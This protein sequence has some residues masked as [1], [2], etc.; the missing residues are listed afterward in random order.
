MRVVVVF[1]STTT[2]DLRM[3]RP[4]LL[5][6]GG[7]LRSRLVR[8]LPVFVRCTRPADPR[9]VGMFARHQRSCWYPWLIVF[10]FIF[11][12]RPCSARLRT[13]SSGLVGDLNR[14]EAPG[15]ASIEGHLQPGEE[16][17]APFEGLRWWWRERLPPHACPEPKGWARRLV[18]RTRSLAAKPTSTGPEMLRAAQA[19]E[20]RVQRRA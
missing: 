3:V 11:P 13:R 12:C 14:P 5:P 20:R 17:V 18:G 7:G 1:L 15:Q 19:G 10:R 9:C 16:K 2:G 6:V 4:S 8:V